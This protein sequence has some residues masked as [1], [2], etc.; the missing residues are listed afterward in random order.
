MGASNTRL[1]L[2][3]L[4]L[5]HSC[6]QNFFSVDHTQITGSLIME[7]FLFQLPFHVEA[8]VR[9]VCC[10]QSVDSAYF[11]ICMYHTENQGKKVKA[12]ASL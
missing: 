7:L 12:I 11:S 10:I 4:N 1:L 8:V 5:H 3:L 6:Q 2:N 9:T